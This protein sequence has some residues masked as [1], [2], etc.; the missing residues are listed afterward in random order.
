MASVPPDDGL[1][2][3]ADADADGAD[4]NVG[5]TERGFSITLGAA[6]LAFAAARRRPVP[7]LV[8]AV[9]GAW[10]AHRGIT[11]HCEVYDRLDLGTAG[12]EDDE[13]LDPGA[14][15]D[16]SAEAV[17]TIG[18]PPEEVYG[19]W[20]KLE[21]APRYM[22]GI[23]S[24]EVRGERLSSWT[25][26]GPGGR[27][28]TWESEIVEDR[29]GELI[30]WRSRPGSDVR[31]QGAV[32]FRSAPAGRGT[33]VRLDLELAPAGNAVTRAL[34][35]AGRPLPELVLA[36][37]LRRLKQLLE[38]GETPIAGFPRGPRGD[39]EDA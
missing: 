31:H 26:A 13:R 18:R 8:L 23:Q 14:H 22:H 1:V 16:G 30:A 11:G 37:D 25:A 29:P 19:F 12:D 2:P 33:E 35:R 5:R 39:G 38:A 36:D 9:A 6:L 28:W 27:S 17:I 34:A 24:V 15:D 7:S 3:D 4:V 20:R 21:N 32:R 10:L